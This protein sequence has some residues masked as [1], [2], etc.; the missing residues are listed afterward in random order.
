MHKQERKDEERDG[1]Y[2]DGELL[3][4]VAIA[5]LIL[6]IVGPILYNLFFKGP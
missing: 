6:G 1:H 4:I 3:P 5:A 2:Y